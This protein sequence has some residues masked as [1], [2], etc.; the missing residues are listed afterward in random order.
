M[1]NLT[2]LEAMGVLL[3]GFGFFCL[4]FEAISS[5]IIGLGSR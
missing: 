3:I 4:T 5:W 1:E 2:T